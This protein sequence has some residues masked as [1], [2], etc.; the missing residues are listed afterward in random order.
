MSFSWVLLWKL[1]LSWDSG[2]W[3]CCSFSCPYPSCNHLYFILTLCFNEGLIERLRL[4]TGPLLWVPAFPVPPKSLVALRVSLKVVVETISWW[5][6]LCVCLLFPKSRCPS[7]SSVGQG[8]QIP[9]FGTPLQMSVWT[10]T[11]PKA[12]PQTKLLHEVKFSLQI[13]KAMCI[14]WIS[15]WEIKWLNSHGTPWTL[16]PLWLPKAESHAV[17]LPI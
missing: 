9:V 4:R 11:Q 8:C 6:T 15:S 14:H 2:I 17:P 5:S 3:S 12:V 1:T 7:L 13:N 16:F 10:G